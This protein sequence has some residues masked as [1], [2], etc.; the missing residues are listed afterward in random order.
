MWTRSLAVARAVVGTA[1][2][3]MIAAVGV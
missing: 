3:A 1:I 2:A